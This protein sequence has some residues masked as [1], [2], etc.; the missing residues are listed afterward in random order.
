MQV[1][2]ELLYQKTSV[3]WYWFNNSIKFFFGTNILI[4]LF[5]FLSIGILPFFIGVQGLAC[6]YIW[7]SRYF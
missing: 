5:Y 7:F 1:I 3:W 2:E 6:I 4:M